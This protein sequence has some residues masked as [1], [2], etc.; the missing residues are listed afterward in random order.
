LA[1]LTQIV[2]KNRLISL[3]KRL[4]D[5]LDMSVVFEEPDGSLL[6]V[7][8]KRGGVCRACT[9]FIDIEGQGKNKC[10]YS[11]TINATK[12]QALLRDRSRDV[13]VEFYVCN[14]MLRNFVIPISIGG[15]VLGNV[16]SGQFL[17]KQVKWKDKEDQEA[18]ADM[19][20]LGQTREFVL[21]YARM[22]KVSDIP[23][24]AQDNNIPDT[25]RDKFEFAYQEMFLKAKS[26][27]YVI[28][29]VYLLN[30][31]A[32]TISSLGNA[33]YYIN[34]CIKLDTILPDELK[35]TCESNLD[36][37]RLLVQKITNRPTRELTDEIIKANK[38]I[39]DVL[40][41]VQK[42]EQEYVNSLFFPYRTSLLPMNDAILRCQKELLI[43]EARYQ[44]RELRMDLNKLLRDLDSNPGWFSEAEESTLK[45]CDSL[46]KDNEDAL[47]LDRIRLLQDYDEKVLR[48]IV[49][50]IANVRTSADK[51]TET[52]ASKDEQK[53]GLDQIEN[54]VDH[55]T[56]QTFG[57]QSVREELCDERVLNKLPKDLEELR[58]KLRLR[59]DIVYMNWGSISPSFEFMVKERDQWAF[60]L[61][62]YGPVS[63]HS[64]ELINDSDTKKNVLSNA[65]EAVSELVGCNPE[66][67]VLTTNTTNG[68]LISLLSI[69]FSPKGSEEPDRIIVTNLDYETAY[70]CIGQ[71]ERRFNTKLCVIDLPTDLCTKK[72]AD[73]IILESIDGKTKVVILSHV[74]Y[75]TGQRLDVKDVV[76]K[77]RNSLRE[78]SPLFLIDG[79]QAVGNIQVDVSSLDCEFYAADAHK[80]LMGPTGSGFLYVKESY[81]E[82]H[83]EYFLFHE[84]LR[85]AK[86]FRP[87][88]PRTKKPFEPATMSIDTYLGMARIIRMHLQL[89][90]EANLGQRTRELSEKFKEAVKTNLPSCDLLLNEYCSTPGI[91]AI[92]LKGF[93]NFDVY[94]GIREKLDREYHVKARALSNPSMLRFCI[95]YFNTDWEI[96]YAAKALQRI[97]EQMPRA[98]YVEEIESKPISHIAVGYPYL[99]EL[100]YGGLPS[101]YAVAL[102]SP[103]C[104]E[105]DFLTNTFLETGA[106]EGQVTF[107][108]TID[109]G[110]AKTLAEEFQSNFHLF[111][112][113]PH[114]GAVVEHSPNVFTL[115]GVEN[116]TD[117]S[118]A[119]TSAIR[120]LNQS[121]KGPR[122][123]CIGL[124]SDVLLQHHA[125]QTRRWLTA[126]IAELKST[127]FTIL[128]IMDPQMHPPE[129][130]HAI[131]GLFDGEINIFEKE[132]EKGQKFLK[133]RKMS[134]QQYLDNE[135]PLKREELQKRK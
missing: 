106:K 4:T 84:N 65:R 117:I 41:Q 109:P 23:Q 59:Y 15:E 57:L 92:T 28:A 105:R 49:K 119:L 36:E 51:L 29:A 74:T 114:A 72:I 7:I 121:L 61:D 12:A 120:K 5:S 87:I 134:N 17:V 110:A 69:D 132:T 118:I 90:K 22:P 45:S 131:L 10:L 32:Q 50:S 56:D 86:R 82:R 98:G 2:D 11:D 53:P 14:G 108:V 47:D 124:I 6:N 62:K 112:C 88:N 107:Y 9:E 101:G 91:V 27:K 68:I 81:L 122:R 40:L 103:S 126:L 42:H 52:E 85:V 8:G 99:D 116:L 133:I 18:I 83:K 129:E 31:V 93:E 25:V 125:V 3:Q 111:V 48:E 60:C 95:S 130:Y 79:A 67:V 66:E 26:L 135:A 113:N 24:I 80:W 1:R 128:A 13:I 75:N 43:A 104:D 89:Q 33:Y 102:T 71:I 100:L 21:D 73:R 70:Y 78:K 54:V 63:V 37:I 115:K 44:A 97:I 123:I 46:L 39:Y 76:A 38:L 35:F 96:T 55:L 64:E 19:Q 94:N 34:T 16:F 20:T 127:G 77:V 58:A 30:E